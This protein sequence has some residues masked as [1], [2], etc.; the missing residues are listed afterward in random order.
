MARDRDV[1]NAIQAALMATGAFDNVYLWQLATFSDRSSEDAR[2]AA[3]EPVGWKETDNWDDVASGT[4]EINATCKIAFLARD[5]DEQA[6][7]EACED[8]LNTACNA[9]N[10]QSL[11]D[12]TLPQWT[13]FTDATWKP[14]IPPERQIVTTF[15]YRYLVDNCTSFDITI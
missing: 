15:S 8:L 10:G 5:E 4:I 11:S 6:R 13:K 9:L 2:A 14:A 7:D 1:R 12:L 3:I